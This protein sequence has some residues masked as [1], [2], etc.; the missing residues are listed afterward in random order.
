MRKESRK[1]LS[2]E[3]KKVNES[4]TEIKCSEKKAMKRERKT[5][6]QQQC[7]KEIQYKGKSHQ[8]NLHGNEQTI[9]DTN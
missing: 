4:D 2:T 9:K 7:N 5:L 8:T 3:I 1:A 6:S